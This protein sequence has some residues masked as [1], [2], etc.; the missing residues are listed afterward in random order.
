MKNAHIMLEMAAKC[1]NYARNWGLC[2]SFWIM[3]FEADYAKNDASI[4][5]YQC[6]IA[7]RVS[8][9]SVLCQT[10][11]VLG[12]PSAKS[13]IIGDPMASCPFI[14]WWWPCTWRK[15]PAE[16]KKFIVSLVEWKLQFGLVRLRI[17]PRRWGVRHG[18]SLTRLKGKFGGKWILHMC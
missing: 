15:S 18:V 14:H 6:L 12:T 5:L 4:L 9:R 1:S 17:N 7:V 2:F 8:Q 3:L 10:V 13:S 16:V 11:Q